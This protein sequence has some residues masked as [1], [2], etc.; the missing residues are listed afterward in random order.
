MA[1]DER[2]E[3]QKT[4]NKMWGLKKALIARNLGDI[5]LDLSETICAYCIQNLSSS[6]CG[7]THSVLTKP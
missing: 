6:N 7:T 5:S 1:K 2:I 4:K 3:D